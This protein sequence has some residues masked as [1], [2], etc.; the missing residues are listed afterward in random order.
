MKNNIYRLFLLV[1][2]F[3]GVA[4]CT[5]D[6]DEINNNV[7]SP[8]VDKAAPDQLLTNAIESMT[9]RVHEIFLGHEMGSC[10]AQHM[11]KVQYTDEDRYVYRPDVVNTTWSSFYAA[12]GSDAALIYKLGGERSQPNYQGVA[13]VLQAYIAAELTDLFGDVPYSQA[14]KGAGEDGGILSPE[15]DTQ[16]AIYR[17]IIAKLDEANS[18]LDPDGTAIAGDILFKNDITKW[19]KFANSLRLRLLLRM[20]DRDASLATTEMSKIVGAPATYPIFESNS[21][22]AALIYLGSSP[23]NN[24]INENRKSRDDHRVSKNLIDMLVDMEDDRLMVYA[25]PAEGIDEFVGIPNGLT[26]ADAA[27]YN[28]NGLANTSKIGDYFTA[29]TAPGMLMSYA[30]LQFILAEAAKKGYISGGDASA[31]TYYENGIKGSFEQYRAPLQAVID[32]DGT[33]LGGLTVPTSVDAAAAN[34]IANQAYNA[35]DALRLIA[36]QRYLATFDQGLQT[37]FEWRRTGFPVLTPA[38]SGE[39]GGKIPVR[40]PYPQIEATRNGTNLNTAIARQGADDLNT[41]V[42]WDVN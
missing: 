27:A 11:A 31:Q 4:A 14:W 12:N 3:L 24:P 23:N 16:E 17:D 33:T 10:W 35:N 42:W 40:V 20:S 2:F 22:N 21:D 7:N 25:N 19:K 1:T 29:A 32:A 15:Y 39:N 5:N 36:T 34:V 41:K 13:L 8:T 28:G 26:S 37:W 38:V 9:D 6:F 18:L 30:E